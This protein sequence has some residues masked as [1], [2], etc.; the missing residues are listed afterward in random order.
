MPSL[1]AKE[2]KAKRSLV[3]KEYNDELLNFVTIQDKMEKILF[4]QWA[5]SSRNR[6][7]IWWNME[8]WWANQEFRDFISKKKY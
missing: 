1:L 3:I 4:Y 2:R 5:A 7:T 8:V 6:L